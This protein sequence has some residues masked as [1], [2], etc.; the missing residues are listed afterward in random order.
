MNKYKVVVVF[1]ML[2]TVTAFSG[3]AVATEEANSGGLGGVR[4]LEQ[5]IA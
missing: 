1:L 3:V 4:M 2:L 5:L